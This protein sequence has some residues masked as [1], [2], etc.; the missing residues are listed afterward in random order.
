MQQ[1]ART[2]LVESRL[3]ICQFTPKPN[4]AVLQSVTR[5]LSAMEKRYAA[6]FQRKKRQTG[7]FFVGEVPPKKTHMT[8]ENHHF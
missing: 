6:A 4:S 7:G 8:L 5:D 2:N 1:I 3:D